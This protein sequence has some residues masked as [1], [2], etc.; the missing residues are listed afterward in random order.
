MPGGRDHPVWAP[1]PDEF[2]RRKR[3]LGW[4]RRRLILR[5][6]ARLPS[7]PLRLLPD[8]LIIGAAKSGT[9][10]LYAH[11]LS[12]PHVAWAL[13]KET[14]YFT[15]TFGRGPSWYRAFFPLASRRSRAEAAGRGPLLV[16]EATP[17]YLFHPHAP[18]RVHGLLPGAKLVVILR[19]PIDR[20]YSFYRHQLNRAFEPLTFDQAVEQEEQRLAGELE[21]TLS[22]ES[23]VSFPLQHRSYLARGRY[24]EQ[25][26][27][28]L[29][30]FPREQ[31]LVLLTDE[32]EADPRGTLRQLT[33][34]LG[35]PALGATGSVRAHEGVAIEAMPPAVR[36][37]LVEHFRPHN[38]RLAAF[39]GREL[40]WDR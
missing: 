32:L 7:A 40:N 19:N 17:D 3:R 36:E 35:I 11:L 38:A 9:T 6:L 28:W 23:Y 10:T 4:R 30:H 27:R 22:D 15:R 13:R 34:F 21:R 2:A 20:A 1:D 29:R 24:M 37:E 16:G 25:I 39:L 33:D 31:L 14:L 18:R 12:S 8:F 26:E 5:L